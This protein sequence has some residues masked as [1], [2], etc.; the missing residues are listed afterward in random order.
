M[1]P[2]SKKIELIPA[3]DI[4]DG[5][6]V[7]LSKGDYDTKKI[8]NENP[9]EVALEFEHHG[10]QRLHVVDLDGAKAGRIINH[11]VLEKL[12]TKTSL[13]IDFGGGLKSTSDLKIAF[14]SGAQMVTGGSIAVKNPDEFT[15]WIDQ[16]G[17]DKIILGSDVKD[18]NIAISGWLETSELDL[19]EFLNDYQSKGITQTI[20]TDI[21]KDGM[22]A[23]PS[24]PLYQEILARFPDLYLIASG[25][26]SHMR[27]IEALQEA[28]VPAVIFGK[29]IYEG[30]IRMTDIE[31]LLR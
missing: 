16:Y 24:I 25:G 15:S 3:I 30:R 8:Y 19:F 27:D 21:S 4:I 23:G 9:L 6:C 28:G 18:R 14:E 29:A 1:T 7:R 22:L 20:C 31:K 5:Q 10:I 13:T 17:S 2:P 26:V 12:A 11:R